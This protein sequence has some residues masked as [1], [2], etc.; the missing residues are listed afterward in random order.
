M[1]RGLIIEDEGASRE[2]YRKERMKAAGLGKN[3]DDVKCPACGKT[4]KRGQAIDSDT[5]CMVC[6]RVQ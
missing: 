1:V 3:P 2:D 6:G 5:V 4:G